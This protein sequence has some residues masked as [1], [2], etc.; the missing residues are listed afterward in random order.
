MPRWQNYPIGWRHDGQVFQQWKLAN[1]IQELRG[2]TFGVSYVKVSQGAG[3]HSEMFIEN[4]DVWMKVKG[5]ESEGTQFWDRPKVWEV[6]L[7]V[8]RVKRAVF[9][10]D[11]E[12]SSVT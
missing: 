7:H 1:D 3:E 5:A 9:C 12:V 2:P 10:L 8:L 4:W 11:G 6:L